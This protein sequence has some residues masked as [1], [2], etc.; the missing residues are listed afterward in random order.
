M[1]QRP[2]SDQLHVSTRRNTA[3]WHTCTHIHIHA[4]MHTHT[5]LAPRNVPAQTSRNR[6]HSAVHSGVCT[7]QA[8]SQLPSG[9]ATRAAMRST[10]WEA[11]LLVMNSRLSAAKSRDRHTH[12][13]SETRAHTA[14]QLEAP[15]GGLES[16]RP[17]TPTD[18]CRR[19]PVEFRVSTWS[20]VLL[21][22]S[23]PAIAAERKG[24]K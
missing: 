13:H 16:S 17:S 12:R 22:G 14:P 20:S 5:L 18:K 9:M 2:W 7:P 15:S 1:G 23:P 4:Y 21:R 24:P 6:P 3:P 10:C 11:F 8:A 19:C